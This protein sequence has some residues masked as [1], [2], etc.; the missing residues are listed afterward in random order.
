MKRIVVTVLTAAAVMCPGQALGRAGSGS[1]GFHS[2]GISSRPSISSR[3]AP[4]YS[5]SYS[6]SRRPSVV[7]VHHYYHAGYYGGHYYSGGY[8]PPSNGG[9]RGLIALIVILGVGAVLFLVLRSRKA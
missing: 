7:V 3:S 2:S 1:A 9:H 8:D 6:G 5:G 4:R